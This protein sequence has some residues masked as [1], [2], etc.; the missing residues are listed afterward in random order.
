MH[1][2]RLSRAEPSIGAPTDDGSV[3]LEEGPLVF[4]PCD[5]IVRIARADE[6]A[7]R[8]HDRA[9]LFRLQAAC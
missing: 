1:F 9:A 5:V 3:I 8:G 6:R 7:V 2:H 4:R